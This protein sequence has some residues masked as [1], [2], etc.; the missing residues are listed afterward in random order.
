MDIRN[1]PLLPDRSYHIYNR[2][3]NGMKVFLEERNYKYFL[4]QY[5]KY[6]HPFVETFAYCLLSNHYHLLIRVRPENEIEKLIPKNTKKPCNFYVSNGFSSFLK[7]YTQ[8][9]NKTYD[10]TG[11]LFETPFKRIEVG[12]DDYFTRLIAYIHLNPQKHMLVK[13]FKTYKHS[14]YNVHLSNQATK[15][16]REE[17]LDWFGGKEAYAKFH[18]DATIELSERLLLE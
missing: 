17:V 1:T 4:N 8:G 2:G 18:S 12:E 10:R 15:L 9:I 14:S 5:A 7:A 13:D 6:V 11:A 16:R 3:I